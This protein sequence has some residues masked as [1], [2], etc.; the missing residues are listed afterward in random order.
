MNS[1]RHQNRDR[2]D[3]GRSGASSHEYYRE[4]DRPTSSE[5]SSMWTAVAQRL[6]GGGA[7][8][9][10]G[11]EAGQGSPHRGAAFHWRSFWMGQAA[12][13]LLLLALFGAYTLWQELGGD[14]APESRLQQT[15]RT[16]LQELASSA[17]FLSTPASEVQQE[18]LDS[19]LRGLQEIDRMIEEMRSDMLLNG[20]TRAK[21]SQLRR[22]YAT[23]L[24]FV[25][26]LILT[27][28]QEASS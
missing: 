18:A 20:S 11:R 28:D 27:E 16:S 24:D 9:T 26:K 17:Q 1:D 7:G 25:Q 3:R 21:R 2:K 8:S 13:V 12:A 5:K 22:L 6:P 19:Q 4:E 15:Y 10:S 14:S 23:K